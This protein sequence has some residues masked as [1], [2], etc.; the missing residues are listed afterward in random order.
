MTGPSTPATAA[1]PRPPE[2]A[3]DD[4]EGQA[5]TFPHL[6]VR[7]VVAGLAL[8][9]LLVWVSVLFDAPLEEIANPDKT[10]NP[11]K[12]PWYFLGLQELLHYYPPVISGV[13][14]PLLVVVLLAIIPYFDMNHLRA[15]MWRGDRRTTAGRAW[16]A[17]LVLT[18]LLLFTGAHPVWPL[19]IPLWL[20]GLGASAGAVRW[21]SAAFRW[22]GARS[23]AFWAF[24]WFLLCS[25]ALTVVGVWFRGPG[26]SF[27]LP[28]V[29][30]VF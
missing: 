2:R 19:I 29:D 30:G 25:V 1:Q 28:W 10:P 26:W 17:I 18:A 22:L 24:T 21:E 9:I 4:D 7:E 23:V 8:C 16:L 5:M 13:F 6:L 11:A 15:P 14:M 3:P 12:A 20:T 27:T